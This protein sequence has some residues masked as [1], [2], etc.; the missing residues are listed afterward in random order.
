MMNKP[1]IS[2]SSGTVWRTIL[3]ILALWFVYLIKDILL[4]LFVAILIVSAAQP[5]VE[6]LEKRRIPRTLTAVILYAIGISFICGVIYLIAPVIVEEFH[7]LSNNLPQYFNGISNFINNLTALAADYNAEDSFQRLIENSSSRITELFSRAFSNAFVF[8]GGLFK[9]LLVFSLS[10]YMLVKK[11]GIRGFLRAVTPKKHQEYVFDLTSRIQY[12]MGRWLVGQFALAVIIF[13]LD[14]IVLSSFGVPYALILALMGGLFE[15]IPYLGPM[16]AFIPAV[17]LSL[18]ISPI[19]ALFVAFLYIAIQQLE[20]NVL[21]PL[22]MKKAVG[23]DPVVIIL[24]LLIGGILAGFLGVL[25]AVPFATAVSVFMND[26]LDNKK[27]GEKLEEIKN[28]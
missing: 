18:T 11:D 9:V 19:T 27:K 14:F 5:I 28:I 20:N 3:I 10:F 4:L 25:I 6:G 21:V 15:V 17:L 1:E 24:S 26:L 23:L 2:I 16:L 22:V 12:K 8:L 7:Q 13:T